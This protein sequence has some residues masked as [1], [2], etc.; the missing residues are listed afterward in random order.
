MFIRKKC[1][2]GVD[3]DHFRSACSASVA[4]GCYMASGGDRLSM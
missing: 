1:I 4:T 3:F 2:D